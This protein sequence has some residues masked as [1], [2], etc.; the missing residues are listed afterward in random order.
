[1]RAM[2]GCQQFAPSRGVAMGITKRGAQAVLLFSV[3]QAINNKE[4]SEMGNYM[5]WMRMRIEELQE[6]VKNNHPKKASDNIAIGPTRPDRP[7]V[8]SLFRPPIQ[9]TA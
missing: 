2:S 6:E 9:P 3:Q 4:G 7:G 8:I 5:R 1:M